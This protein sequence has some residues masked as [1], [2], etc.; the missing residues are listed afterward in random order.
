MK[1]VVINRTGPP[2]VLE[3]RDVEDPRPANGEAVVRVAATGVN[4]IDVWIRSGLY[5]VKLPHVLGVDVAGT[6]ETDTTGSFKPGERVLIY[7][8]VG[9][10]TCELCVSGEEQ[11]CSLSF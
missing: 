2:D 5:P 9:C 3:Y 7:P 10:G 11:I 8:S 1:A 4:R 6:V